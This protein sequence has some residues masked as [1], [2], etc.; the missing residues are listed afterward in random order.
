MTRKLELSKNVDLLQTVKHIIHKNVLQKHPQR[1]DCKM[2]SLAS[3]KSES[4]QKT[5]KQLMTLTW[6][7]WHNLQYYA[8]GHS[9]EEEEKKI[10]TM[11]FSKMNRNISVDSVRFMNSD[12][13]VLIID[14]IIFFP[15]PLP[16]APNQKENQKFSPSTHSW[17][18]Q[19]PCWSCEDRP[20]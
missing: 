1:L 19:G 13:A 8:G 10:F 18:P 15:T 12:T 5:V 4:K 20:P 17:C 14:K 3:I 2:L 7:Q 6:T 16:R 11:T 9:T